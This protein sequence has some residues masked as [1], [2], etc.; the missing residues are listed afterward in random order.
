MSILKRFSLLGDVYIALQ[1]ALWP[2]LNHICATPSLLFHPRAVARIFMSIV[3]TG[4][5]AGID[6]SNAQLKASL[7]TQNAYG[8]VLDLG[9]GHGHLAKYLDRIRVTKYV[10]L[11]PNVY[12]HDKIRHAAGAAGFSEVAGTFVL[13]AC[14]A[15]DTTTILISLG[16]YQ[17][18]DTLVSVLTLCS[19]P[20]PQET[21]KS[22]ATEVLKPGGQVL[23]FEHVQNPHPQVAWWQT[24]WSPLW[25]LAFDGCQL[26][27]PTH[28]WIQQVGGWA[29]EEVTGV[30]G[31]DEEHLFCCR[32]GKFVKA[33]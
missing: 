13:L 16:G 23:F 28:T 17:P 10:A 11:E 21:I 33:T 30:D 27:R 18:V 4:F 24:F 9:A 15:E 29:S 2:T 31:E 19:V 14:G 32:L 6:E 25:A 12:M 5:G 8:V 1:L 20:G 3:W 7:I 26:G 22:L